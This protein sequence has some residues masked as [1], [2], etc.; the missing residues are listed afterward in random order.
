MVETKK[1]TEISRSD[2]LDLAAYDKVRA[3][4]RKAIGDVKAK[5]RV[6]VGP[7]A[8]FYFESFDTM[9]Y[10]VQEMLRAERGG[11]EQLKEELA[12]YNPMIP[13]GS[14][15][16]ATV[17][18]E[19]A[20]PDVRHRFLSQLGGVEDRFFM[21]I[22]GERVEARPERDVERTKAD[23]KTSSVHFIHIELTPAQIAKFKDKARVL[24]GVEHPH[25]GHV[26]IL[27]DETRKE[28]ASDLAG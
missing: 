2:I 6:P 19:I 4:R 20:D 21:E 9:L 28:L 26:A 3:E 14:D 17:M 11:D 13:K 10:Q 5:R 24:V 8:T 18:F 25:Y 1:K 12:A 7:H 15:L 22:G 27:S 23:G 16:A